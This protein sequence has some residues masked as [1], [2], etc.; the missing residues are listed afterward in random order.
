M[1]RL[2]RAMFVELQGNN[3][4]LV[5]GTPAFEQ[6]LRKRLPSWPCTTRLRSVATGFRC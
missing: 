1:A 5:E 6:F 3:H 4:V 2:M